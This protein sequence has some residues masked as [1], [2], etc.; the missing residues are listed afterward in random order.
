MLC[1]PGHGGSTAPLA[2]GSPRAMLFL[3]SNSAMKNER[4]VGKGQ[5]ERERVRDNSGRKGA[6]AAIDGCD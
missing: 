1:N 6:G 2:T 4:K 3:K 5:A